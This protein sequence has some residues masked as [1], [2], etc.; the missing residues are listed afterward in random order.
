MND[1]IRNPWFWLGLVSLIFA[2]AGVDFNTLTSW[3]LLADALFSILQNPVSLVAVIGGLIG[4]FNDNGTPG[5]DKIKSGKS[6]PQPTTITD[7]SQHIPGVC[8]DAANNK[9]KA[10]IGVDGKQRHLGY[11][12][13][14][15]DAIDARKKAEE[16]FKCDW[17]FKNRDR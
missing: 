7:K 1:K 3:Q 13:S 5:L 2:S 16:I 12:D 15:D 9:W 4:V 10:Y 14:K 8:W 17:A 11:Y 6:E